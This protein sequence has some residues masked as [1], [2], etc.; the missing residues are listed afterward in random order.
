[1]NPKTSSR[2]VRSPSLLRSLASFAALNVVALLLAPAF[3]LAIALDL[4]G[5]ALSCRPALRLADR[6]GTAAVDALEVA[7]AALGWDL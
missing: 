2:Q 5:S 3:A 4:V 1:M 6:V 7:A